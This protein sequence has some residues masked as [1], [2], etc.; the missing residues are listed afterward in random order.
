MLP[1]SAC[2]HEDLGLHGWSAAELVEAATRCGEPEAAL[3]A[4]ERLAE[5]ASIGG[6][7]WP[8]ASKR[9]AGRW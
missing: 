5:T 1:G 8:V 2:E 9:G 4:V 3:A 7:D 6:T